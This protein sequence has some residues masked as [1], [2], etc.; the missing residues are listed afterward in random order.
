ME[1]TKKEYWKL[2]ELIGI[3]HKEIEHNDNIS[4]DTIRKAYQD[5]DKILSDV[6]IRSD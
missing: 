5:M 6:L 1:I 2:Q 4:I 3:I